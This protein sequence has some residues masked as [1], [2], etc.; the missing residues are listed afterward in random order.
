MYH[1]LFVE[2]GS[3]LDQ[4]MESLLGREGDIQISGI[5]YSDDDAF[6]RQISD[7]RPDVILTNAEGPLNSI[8]ILELLEANPTLTTLKVIMVRPD[9]NV[10][11]V[12][13]RQ[14]VTARRSADLI[15]LI[16]RDSDR[17]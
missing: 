15:A 3:L 2:S 6:L 9:D 8:Q 5:T 12:Y 7:L 1:V 14:Q 16:R 4:G 13:E 10:I 17:R 11:D